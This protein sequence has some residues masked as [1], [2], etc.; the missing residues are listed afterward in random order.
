M[1]FRDQFGWKKL[2]QIVP[3]IGIIFGAMFNK[4]FIEDIAETGKMLYRKRRILE[5]LAEMDSVV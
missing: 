1:T 3:I 4:M 5:K 2:F